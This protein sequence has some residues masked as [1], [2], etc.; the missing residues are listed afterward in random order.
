MKEVCYNKDEEHVAIVDE[1]KIEPEEGDKENPIETFLEDVNYNGF[2]YNIM[3][4]L[5]IMYFS[6]GSLIIFFMM[7]S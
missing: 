2:H 3:F 7:F 6:L 4:I 1:T 5:A